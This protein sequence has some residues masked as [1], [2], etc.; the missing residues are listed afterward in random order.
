MKILCRLTVLTVLAGVFVS[1]AS[2]AGMKAAAGSDQS[3]LLT[4]SFLPAALDPD[5]FTLAPDYFNVTVRRVMV[6]KS[7]SDDWKTIFDGSSRIDIVQGGIFTPDVVPVDDGEY[8]GLA[9]AYQIDW[10]AGAEVTSNTVPVGLPYSPYDYVHTN[11]T[12]TNWN[13][14][15]FATSDLYNEVVTEYPDWSNRIN[16]LGSSV[17]V[18]GGKTYVLNYQFQTS[19][20]IVVTTN[21]NSATAAFVEPGLTVTA[22]EA[23]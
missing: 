12:S 21:S 22:V 14:V 8:R 18:E 20:M 4:R 1:C 15:F 6:R 11:S 19:A 7:L 13:Y 10:I 3:G 16:T 9:I 17:L 2:Q 23:E 5:Q